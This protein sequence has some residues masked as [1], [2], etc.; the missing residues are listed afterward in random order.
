VTSTNP[1]VVLAQGI[2]YPASEKDPNRLRAPLLVA[3]PAGREAF[4]SLAE[5]ARREH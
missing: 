4:P 5:D 2:F 3:T 1:A